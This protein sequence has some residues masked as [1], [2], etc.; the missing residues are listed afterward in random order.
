MVV[1]AVPRAP[2]GA[3][4]SGETRCACEAAVARRDLGRP[5]IV[6]T[7]AAC[8]ASAAS[9]QCLGVGPGPLRV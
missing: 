5:V 8:G 4:F 2:E 7:A 9:G 6:A 3:V 1:R